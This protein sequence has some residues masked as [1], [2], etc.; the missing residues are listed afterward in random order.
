[1]EEPVPLKIIGTRQRKL[2]GR[3]K[4]LGRTVF[5]S[6]LRLPGMLIGKILRSP[7]AHARVRSI[8]VSAAERVPG[9]HAVVHAGNVSQRPFGYGSDNVPLKGGKVPCAGD[10][11]AAVA[12]ENEDAAALALDLIAVDYEVL[13]A[14]FDPFEVRRPGGPVDPRRTRRHRGQRVHALGLRAWRCRSGGP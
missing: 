9:V 13:P 8:D 4:V 6:D 12:A 10:E 14:V 7:H 2:D 11:V 3:D 5:A 1:M